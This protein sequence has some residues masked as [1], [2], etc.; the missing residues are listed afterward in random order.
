[1]DT[2]NADFA[3]LISANDISLN[4][5]QDIFYAGNLLLGKKW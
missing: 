4:K 3:S 5:N 2:A 1:M